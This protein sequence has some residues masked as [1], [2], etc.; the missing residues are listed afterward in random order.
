MIANSGKK[1]ILIAWVIF[2]LYILI[3]SFSYLLFAILIILHL[4]YKSPEREIIDDNNDIVLS[5]SDGKIIA[6]NIDET[7]KE[8]SV[9]LQKT[10]LSS[11]IFSSELRAPIK[12]ENAQNIIKNGMKYNSNY[13]SNANY[14]VFDKGISTLI[15]PAKFS[16][17]NIQLCSPIRK[18]QRIGLLTSGLIELKLPYSSTLLVGIGD[19]I[20]A[21]NPIANIGE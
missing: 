4:L 5:P 11:L 21:N 9:T 15:K 3:F 6:I 10:Y 2:I 13:F 8:L 18:G 7:N 12:C 17:K 19:K 1:V 20:L 16:I 14:I